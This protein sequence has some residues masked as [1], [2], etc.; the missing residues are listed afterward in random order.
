MLLTRSRGSGP[1]M[2]TSP[3]CT[4]A[5][6]LPRHCVSK[7]SGSSSRA[8]TFWQSDAEKHTSTDDFPS[9]PAGGCSARV[10]L[11]VPPA[12]LR[13]SKSCVSYVA[14]QGSARSTRRASAWRTVGAA[15]LQESRAQRALCRSSSAEAAAPAAGFFHGFGS[16]RGG[17]WMTSK[18]E[19]MRIRFVL[20]RGGTS[21]ALFLRRHELPADPVLRDRV[22]LELFGSP[23][24]RQIDGLGGADLLTNKLAIIGAA[25]TDADLDYTFGQVSITE[26]LISY[27]MNCGNISAAVGAYAVDEGLVEPVEDRAHVRIYNTN[28]GRVLLAEVLVVGGLA[29]GAGGFPMDGV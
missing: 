23:D 27:D 15:R 20:I 10:I 17:A 9:T 1:R 29:A 21:K 7:G 22:I 18:S 14:R 2:L 28:T 3:R 25:T 11:S 26:S 12:P 8:R 5:S 4:T 19:Q 6:A 13:S 16:Q 24:A